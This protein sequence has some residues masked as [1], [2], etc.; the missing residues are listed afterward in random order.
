MQNI[1]DQQKICVIGLGYVGLPLFVLAAQNNYSVLG[2]DLDKDKIDNLKYG[3]SYNQEISDY[4]IQTFLTKDFVT[5]STDYSGLSSCDVIVV[6]VPTPLSAKG[7]PDYSL[8]SRAV[9]EIALRLRQGQLV[10]IESTVAPGTTKNLVLS[11]LQAGGLS[12]G[13]DFFLSY[14]PERIDPG[15]KSYKLN[16]IPK[17]AAGA[18]HICRLLAQNFYS[19]LGLTV[20]PVPSLAVAEMAKLLENTYR[21]VNIALVNEMAQICHANNINIWDVI[22]AAATKPFG[23]HAFYPGVGVGGHCVPI[24]SVYF[25]HWAWEKGTSAKL[26]ELARKIN[27]EMPS[28]ITNIIINTLAASNKI[29]R[30]SKI[31]ILGVSYKKDTNDVRESSALKLITQ[32]QMEGAQVSFHD[33][34]VESIEINSTILHRVT[35]DSNFI[36]QQDCVVLALAHSAYN[37]SGIYSA[38]TSIID[39]TNAMA[40]YP[41]NRLTRL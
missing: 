34:M 35:P 21:D 2:I 37:L 38:S 22:N 8:L 1:S 15:N 12:V 9:D 20:I 26:C 41:E 19:S 17:L 29:L 3:K 5:I 39:L 10:I 40:D 6:C 32:L 31:L 4:D 23:F 11:R 30:G 24:D 33:P 25:T 13:T 36:S 28:Y 18:T 14:S 16:N 27:T 7:K